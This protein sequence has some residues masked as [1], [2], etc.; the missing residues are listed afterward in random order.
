[1][2]NT[3]ALGGSPLGLINVRSRPTN[4]GMSTFNAGK[5]RNMNVFSYNRGVSQPTGIQI[6]GKEAYSPVSLMSGGSLPAF[7]PNADIGK[8]G[9]EHV[10]SGIPQNDEVRSYQA[11]RGVGVSSDLHNDAAYDTSLLNI[12]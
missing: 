11:A 4:T 8:I 2:A 1:M 5:S 10:F 3:F 12:I 6:D 7:F 9:S